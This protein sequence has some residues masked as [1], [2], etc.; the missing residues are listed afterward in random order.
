MSTSSDTDRTH[1]RLEVVGRAFPQLTADDCAALMAAAKR[2]RHTAGAVLLEQGSRRQ[3]IFVLESGYVSVRPSP[4]GHA[5]AIARLGPGNVF[6]EMS[7]VEHG[8]ASANV[9]AETDVEVDVVESDTLISLLDTVPG[10]SARFY[11]SL[12]TSLSQRLRDANTRLASRFIE[13]LPQFT[14]LSSP[15]SVSDA[16]LDSELV[17]TLFAFKREM[18]DIDRLLLKRNHDEA[19]VARRVDAAL[20]ALEQGLT[21][22]I[23]TDPSL[24][25]D[26]G[27][28]VFREA[29]PFLTLSRTY[30]RCFSK[31][32]GYAGDYLTIE[33]MYD[34][35]PQGD[36]R[37]GRHIDRWFLSTP[38]ARAVKNRRQLVCETLR[39]LAEGRTNDAPLRV[40]SLA[41]G[42]AREL[43][44]LY[45]SDSVPHI[46]ATCI[47][48]D[49]DA[50]EYASEKAVAFGV[51]DRMRFVRDN[52]V[53]LSLGRGH[54]VLPPQDVIY[55]IG[56]TDYLTD[57]Q[58]VDLCS[59][60]H[61]NLE[62]GGTAFIGN[63]AAGQPN[64]MLMDNL[65][66]WRLI[67]RTPEEMTALFGRSRFGEAP[68]EV[69]FEPAGVNLFAFCRKP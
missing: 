64:R 61:D 9:L 17:I 12:A 48:I 20:T 50:L 34:D 40:T 24:A 14:R 41:C 53:L 55:S 8:E 67:H 59:W 18:M 21:R 39:D 37:L 28:H 29:F 13:D 42:P 11:A 32:R 47:D 23:E 56:L 7:F 31:P 51:S 69:R 63:F 36:R 35:V 46:E 65:L 1:S 38:A 58:V 10:L 27:A 2:S 25:A 15:R 60:M 26:I 62:R 4:L 49:R 68:V 3:A 6:G 57:D 22:Q 43:F 5:I 16:V 54:T 66:E 33:M 44:D 30:D 45:G 19:E 52:V